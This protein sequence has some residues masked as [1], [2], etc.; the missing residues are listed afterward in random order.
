MAKKNRSR[1]R[2]CGL[3]RGS[4][5]N[6][7]SCKTAKASSHVLVLVHTAH[8][9][10]HS[11]HVVNLRPSKE[12][13]TLRDVLAFEE[14][15]RS[16][17]ARETYDFAKAIR[18]KK[19][20]EAFEDVLFEHI[21]EPLAEQVVQIESPGVPES[22]ALPEPFVSAG[23]STQPK[24]W[25]ASV[26]GI[27]F[28]SIAVSLILVALLPFPAFS[29]Y[30]QL[31]QTG[32]E[33][34]NASASGFL[35]LQAS[36]IEALNSDTGGAQQDIS[37]ALKSFSQARSILDENHRA[38]QF[39]VRSLPIVGDAFEGRS[40]LLEA[41]HHMA[42][43]HTY[44]IKG[45]REVQESNLAISDK[46]LLLKDH[47]RAAR[48]QYQQALFS[49]AS[50][51]SAS[52][53][54]TYQSPL[55]EFEVLFA[56][57]VDDMSEI[58]TLIDALATVIGQDDF[59]RYLIVF[60]NEG[61]LRA[62]G[63]FIGSFAT[64]DFQKGKLLGCDIPAGG[65]YDLKGQLGSYV[66]PPVPLQL[67]NGRWEFQDANWW[68]DFSTSA[69]KLAWFYEQSE[70]TTVDG[71]IAINSSVLEDFLSIVGPIENREN[72]VVLTA[73]SAIDTLQYKV[74]VDYDKK[75]NKPKAIIGDLAEQFIAMTQHMSQK[76]IMK[77]I[78]A[79]HKNANQKNIQFYFTDDQV[80]QRFQKFGWAGEVLQTQAGQDYLFVVNSNIQGQ[81]SDAKIEQEIEHQAAI[82][83]DGR[84]IVTTVVRRSHTGSPGEQF[85]GG[86]NI[87]YTRLY[88]PKG[89][90]LVDAGGFEYPPED[91]F[92]V[93][94]SWYTQDKDLER[95]E[96]G[97]RVHLDSGTRVTEQFG[98]TVFGNWMITEP[99]KTTEAY[100]VYELP[101]TVAFAVQP[102]ARVA[103]WTDKL[104]PAQMK[105]A[106]KYGLV[107][108]S[109]S[110]N[111]SH[112][113][114]SIIY[115]DGWEPAWR[116]DESLTLASNGATVETL[117][118]QDK[119]FGL[120]MQKKS[121]E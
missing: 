71:V 93:P 48:P 15:K 22:T 57:F 51:S 92:H 23:R 67:V 3:C 8:T 47:I 84:I 101:F 119:I 118:I 79:L 105:E 117:L 53:P 9:A 60:Q 69:Q 43:G 113:Y 121:D 27:K 49:L 19:Q 31:Q 68:P 41:G 90:V 80:E 46:L 5:H 111:T 86:P 20:E 16:L 44:L 103:A 32:E 108:Q 36:S 62:T 10:G 35:A 37:V 64:C 13:E 4:G 76:D 99:G 110:G 34:M 102:E 7:R 18:E 78:G 106:S 42:L 77:V 63:G 74:E 50:A 95:I 65:S 104:F 98:K 29:Y 58:E 6:K 33:V 97:E 1:V 45:I 59:R 120:V 14:T 94:E 107:V 26:S 25:F 75:E 11:E 24:E 83:E 88:V 115:P 72:D 96:Q 28:A 81:K 30:K 2:C 39:V 40:A 55:K 89:A 91:A 112:F 61:E 54:A 85:Y 17:P 56:T 109:Q 21:Q 66:K 70:H 52:L 12:E 116:S 100:V 87:S 82:Q 114:S 38:L 73:D